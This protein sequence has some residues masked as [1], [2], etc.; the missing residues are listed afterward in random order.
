MATIQPR[1][2]SERKRGAQPGHKGMY[3]AVRVQPPLLDTPAKAVNPLKP[4]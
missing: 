2:A 4:A 3:R 1:R